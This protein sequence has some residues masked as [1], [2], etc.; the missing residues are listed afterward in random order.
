M[1]RWIVG[2]TVFCLVSAALG[3]GHI[4]PMESNT[5]SMWLALTALSGT[6]LVCSFDAFETQTNHASSDIDEES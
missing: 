1:L 4:M 5:Q 2:L 3:L 6:L